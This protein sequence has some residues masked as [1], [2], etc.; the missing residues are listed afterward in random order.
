VT[1]AELCRGAAEVIRARGWFQGRFSEGPCGPVCAIGALNVAAGHAPNH[2]GERT[3]DHFD[4]P[5]HRAVLETLVRDGAAHEAHD[6]RVIGWRI[7]QWN[8]SPTRTVGDVLNV[9]ERT[10]MRL[11]AAS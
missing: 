8:D 1:P 4:Q 11:E 6:D 7:M 5:E 2:M 9:L 3:F 10:A